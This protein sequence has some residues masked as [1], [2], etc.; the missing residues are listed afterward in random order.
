M[1]CFM[2]VMQ[3]AR[4]DQRWASCNEENR[5]GAGQG[6]SLGPSCFLLK[7]EACPYEEK[8]TKMPF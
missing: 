6:Q 2:P 3:M 1:G 8:K 7:E 5:K 4:I